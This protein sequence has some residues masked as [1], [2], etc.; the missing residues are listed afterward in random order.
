MRRL[1]DPEVK[2]LALEAGLNE[3]SRSCMSPDTLSYNRPVERPW[4]VLGREVATLLVRRKRRKAPVPERREVVQRPPLWT[5][6]YPLALTLG[7]GHEP[8]GTAAITFGLSGFG[9]LASRLPRFCPLAI[10]ITCPPRAQLHRGE[11]GTV[12]ATASE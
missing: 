12:L 8:W 2:A 4:P 5:V 7:G 9:F 6:P 10:G 3:S 1:L 11:T